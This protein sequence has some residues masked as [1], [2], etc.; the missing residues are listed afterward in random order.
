MTMED[1]GRL[2]HW[3]LWAAFAA[4]MAFGAI[5]QRTGFC[6]MGA[7]TD[8]AGLG[9]WTRM[10][11]WALAAA[12]AMAGF[13]LLAAT[14]VLTP[15]Q[16]LYASNRWLWLSA[17]AGGIVFGFGMVL[18]SGCASKTLVRI[19]GGNLKSLVVVLVIGITAFATLKGLTA[20][21]RTASVDRVGVDFATNASLAP[22]LARSAGV[23]LQA[24]SLGLG[25]GI[26]ALLA[27]WALSARE[28]RRGTN[29]LAGLGIG[30]TVVAMWWITGRLGH[31]AEHPETLADTFLATNSTRAEALSFIS[32]VA[33]ALDWLLFYS[34]A[35]KHLTVGIV[36]V[37][38]VVC[39]S[40]LVA[41]ARR[42]FRWEGFAGTADLG[43]HLAGGAL[44]GVG[45]VTALGCTIGQGVSGL[46]TLSL[47]SVTALAAMLAGAWMGLKYQVW[48]LGRDT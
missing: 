17:L 28:L 14:G 19:G 35:N 37:A 30:A 21:L 33:Y 47:T 2:T 26:A 31:V 32:P 36:S 34:D 9:D 3:V 16:T 13:A 39:G 44:M 4:A 43:H 27:G 38:G 25:L 18:A 45:G 42:T 48:R 46:S 22:L 41:L 40:A 29:L 8:A 10:R 5:V 24:A 11:Q 1:V 6:T 20:V 7:V 23:P 15:E 12:T